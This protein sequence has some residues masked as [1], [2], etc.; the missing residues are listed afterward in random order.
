MTAAPAAGR[1]RV[2]VVGVL[3]ALLGLIAPY[4]LAIQPLGRDEAAASMPLAQAP[5]PSPGPTPTAPPVETFEVFTARD[6]FQQ[7]VE[8]PAED[9]AGGAQPSPGA[10]PGTTV[11]TPGG[12]TVTTPGGTTITTPGGTT[13]T[14][15]PGATPSPTATPSPGTTSSPGAGPGP[16]PTASASPG[17]PGGGGGGQG[18]GGGAGGGGA[19]GSTQVGAT[20]VEL[21]DVF[22]SGGAP[23]VSVAVNGTGYTVG[24]GAE[25]G[26]RFR[27]LDVSGTCATFLFGDSRFTLCEGESI[28]K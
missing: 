17:A 11:T 8:A 13:V 18:G 27:L 24:E 26:D 16:T 19:G 22:E 20:R 10:S 12:T 2:L 25:F 5:A 14:T 3:G 4:V 28:R 6:P 1:R 21:I 15:S 7:L 23:T 9:A